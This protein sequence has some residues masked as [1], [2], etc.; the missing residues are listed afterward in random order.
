MSDGVT[1]TKR[2]RCVYT[3]CIYATYRA[4]V[5]GRNNNKNVVRM[6]GVAW[7]ASLCAEDT[8]NAVGG[9]NR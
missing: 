5:L 9:M 7:R 1:K 4:G 3:Y 2:Y 6:C 8:E